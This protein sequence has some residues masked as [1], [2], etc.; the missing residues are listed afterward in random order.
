ML[1]FQGAC[2]SGGLE[3][4]TVDG[5][6]TS[7]AVPRIDERVWEQLSLSARLC[8]IIAAGIIT[9]YK[10]S[11]APATPLSFLAIDLARRSIANPVIAA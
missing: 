3:I 7:V 4:S 9:S 2:H 10:L 6:L 5:A 1:A 8:T 11:R